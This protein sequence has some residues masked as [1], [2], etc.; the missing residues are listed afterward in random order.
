[1]LNK[2]I[3]KK[4]LSRFVIIVNNI[5]EHKNYTA[6]WVKNNNKNN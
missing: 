5:L 6:N 3:F 1:M 2:F 4:I